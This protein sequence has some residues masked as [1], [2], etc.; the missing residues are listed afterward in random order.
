MPGKGEVKMAIDG[1]G[2]FP[3]QLECR[4]SR[5]TT[6]ESGGSRAPAPER[7]PV[8]FPVRTMQGVFM[9]DDG[10]FP[11]ING[12]SYVVGERV[13]GGDVMVKAIESQSVDVEL[14]GEIKQVTM[15]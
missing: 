10:V 11:I 1:L 12:R 13:A 9:A 14:D 2:T 6:E 5:T 3:H 7:V 8:K 15:N 4:S